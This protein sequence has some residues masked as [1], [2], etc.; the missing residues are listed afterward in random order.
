MSEVKTA[1]ELAED[2][3]RERKR[4]Y[5]PGMQDGVAQKQIDHAANK[6]AQP[7]KESKQVV[8]EKDIKVRDEIHLM[9]KMKRTVTGQ[10]IYGWEIPKNLKDCTYLLHI[11]KLEIDKK[12]RKNNKS[13]LKL[14]RRIKR[15]L[16]RKLTIP[17]KYYE[18]KLEVVKDGKVIIPSDLN[19]AT[20]L[21]EMI[22]M[23]V[24]KQLAMIISP[25]QMQPG[26]SM[27]QNYTKHGKLKRR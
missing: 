3:A 16:D 2:T 22:T 25:L 23:S 12:L 4:S 19:D 20:Y 18:T 9:I 15:K 1:K 7:D 13:H 6:I 10:E 14:Y 27:P 17:N 24:T 11:M 8:K 26:M 21:F 5:I